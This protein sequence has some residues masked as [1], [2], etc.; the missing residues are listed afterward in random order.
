MEHGAHGQGRNAVDR[1]AMG[2]SQTQDIASMRRIA[3]VIY[4]NAI[5]RPVQ[6]RFA[7]QRRLNGIWIV[8]IWGAASLWFALIVGRW[9]DSGDIGYSSFGFRI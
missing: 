6:D 4:K 2:R 9:V 8:G 3:T 1:M 5:R 7:L